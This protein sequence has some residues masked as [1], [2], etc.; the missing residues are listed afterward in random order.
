MS[1]YANL[2]KASLCKENR[3]LLSVTIMTLMNKNSNNNQKDL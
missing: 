3:I 2:N 1:Q